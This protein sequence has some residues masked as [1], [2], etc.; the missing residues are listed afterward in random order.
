V[1]VGRK[2]EHAF[3]Q[4]FRV[5]E[6]IQLHADARK[7]AHRFDILWASFQII[8]DDAF[9]FVDF[10]IGKHARRGD[11]GGRQGF[12][13]GD[14]AGGNFG[15]VGSAAGAEQNFQRVPAADGS[16]KARQQWPRS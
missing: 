13:F 16:C 10:A 2:G 15:I 5:V 7:Q 8:P 11:D 9:G 14:V 12:Q 1:I 4:E 6:N 3:K